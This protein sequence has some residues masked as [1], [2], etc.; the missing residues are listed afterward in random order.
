M[1]IRFEEALAATVASIPH[2]KV[3]TCG[4][5]AR[6]LGD[7]RAARAVAEWLAERPYLDPGGQVVRADGR[8]VLSRA[9]AP[10]PAR[11]R[12]SPPRPADRGAFVDR[13]DGPSLLSDLRNEQ[14]RLAAQVRERDGPLSVRTLGGV[15]VAYMGQK[16]IA[17]AALLDATTLEVLETAVRT[18]DVDFPYIPSYLAFREFPAV[19]EAVRG[20]SRTPDLLFV[21]GHGRLHPALFGFAC[22]AGVSLDLPTIGV[23][24]HPL[25]GTPRP[26]QSTEDGAIPIELQGEVRGY[27]WRPPRASRAFYVSVG[28]RLSL[29]NALAWARA[30]TRDHYPEPLRVADRLSKEAKGSRPG[31]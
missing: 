10:L 20:L 23:A 18:V 16:G 4:V 8:P 7:V 13:L 21:D 6:T 3:A 27:A 22:F 11:S 12:E 15:D 19:R 31:R 14:V 30:S 17:A 9:G 2:G 26:T 29:E 28:H 24:K 1:S 5:V 25:A